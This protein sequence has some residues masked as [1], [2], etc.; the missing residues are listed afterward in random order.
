M[1]T[2]KQARRMV[3]KSRRRVWRVA[4]TIVRPET[5]AEWQRHPLNDP[6]LGRAYTPNERAWLICGKWLPGYCFTIEQRERLLAALEEF[7]KRRLAQTRLEVAYG[8]RA[9]ARYQATKKEA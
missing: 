1:L 2:L 8:E 7:V 5:L 9:W 6:I 4:R 3:A